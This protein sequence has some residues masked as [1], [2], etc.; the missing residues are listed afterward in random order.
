MGGSTSTL[1]LRVAA[2]DR[3]EVEAQAVDVHLRHP[4]AQAVENQFADDGMVAIDGVAAAGEV[5]VIA[6]RPE[7]V[8]KLIVQAAKGIGSAAVVAF[9]GVVEDDIEN[10][11]DAGAGGRRAPCREIR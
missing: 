3:G 5:E 9:A 11:F 7:H 8:I 10:D 2:E 6:V 1:P 4:E